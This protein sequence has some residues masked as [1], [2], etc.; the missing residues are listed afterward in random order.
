MF[1]F[2]LARWVLLLG[3]LVAAGCEVPDRQGAAPAVPDRQS[4]DLIFTNA[5]VY[6]MNPDQPRAEAVAI[7]GGQILAVG[8]SA[9]ISAAYEGPVRDLG[10]QMLLPGFHDAHAHPIGGGLQLMGCDLSGIREQA[11]LLDAIRACAA[12]DP[13]GEWLIGEGW[14]LS[15][16][17]PE[18]NPTRDL[19]DAIDAD[20]PVLMRA[21]DGHSS[22][23]NSAAL[24]RAGISADTPDPRN[25]VIERDGDG[26]PSGTLRESAQ[27]L[28]EAV[29]PP[30]THAQRL[31]G[32]RTALRHANSFGI[33]S[34][35]DASV[36][37]EEL[38]VWHDLE[39]SGELSARIVASIRV[40]GMADNV[41]PDLIDPGS[42]GSGALVRADSAKLF[43][44]GVLE[45]ETAALL[46]PYIG[47]GGAS[48]TLNVPWDDLVATVTALDAQGVQIHMHAIGDA[49]VRQGLDALEAARQVNGPNDNRHH[50]CHL[51]LVDPADYARFGEL[52]VRANF[53]AVWA[54]PDAYITDVNLPVV[55]Q[56][57]VDRMYPIGSIARAGGIIVGGSDWSVSSMNPLD[58]IEV[59]VT[60]RDPDGIVDGVLNADEAVP[61]DTMLAAYTRNAAELM[62]QEDQTGTIEPGKAADLVVLARDLYALPAT[63]ISEVPVTLTLFQGRIVYDAD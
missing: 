4:A 61:L 55:G 33:T 26:A 23:V 32:A 27:G 54:Y 6:T 9:D 43:L 29:V 11:V 35:I 3:A 19:L 48:G 30:L 7:G 58:A 59:G 31:E 41:N 18:G 51:Q 2:S 8:S 16:F 60:R 46:E 57:R 56:E 5:A 62:H 45:G 40:R 15:A 25:G 37:P 53:Q 17:P 50:I 28:V 24:R 22:W 21:A 34:I 44:D 38:A 20:R 10:G 14:E 1:R 36:G 39:A 52:G 49:A 12:A 47:R 63:E 42:R 13:D